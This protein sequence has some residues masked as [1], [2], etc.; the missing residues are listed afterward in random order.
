MLCNVIAWLRG[1]AAAAGPN[2]IPDSL[3]H[4]AKRV[5]KRRRVSTAIDTPT[6]MMLKAE[7]NIVVV[8]V[9]VVLCP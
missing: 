2:N 9:V 1:A 6:D 5:N 3:D 8:V 7:G 4:R